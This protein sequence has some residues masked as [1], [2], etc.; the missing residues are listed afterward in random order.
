MARYTA[1]GPGSEN[2]NW[3]ASDK[4]LAVM[5]LN[6][7]GKIDNKDTI[8]LYKYLNNDPAYMDLGLAFYTYDTYK[9]DEDE[10]NVENLLIID[11]HYDKEVNIP[12]LDFV[13]DDWIIHEKFFNY[14]LDM[15]I[16]KYTNSE[17]ITYLQKLLKEAYPEHSYDL[18]FFYP[19]YYNDNMRTIVKDYQKSKIHY[20]YGDLNKD[21]EINNIDLKLLRN[22]LDDDNVI[23]YN[24]ITEYLNNEIELTDDQIKELDTDNNGIIDYIDRDYYLDLV[25]STFSSIFRTR[26][27][28]NQDG[29]ID[30][31]DY[32]LMQACI[33]GE[34]D[35]LKQYDISFILGWCDVQTEALLEEDYNYTGNISE[36]SK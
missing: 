16:Q 29:K 10:E 7:D 22:Y 11:G 35:E 21:G 2:L 1:Q 9:E 12:F 8:V 17:D 13:S 34:S 31:Y 33:N 20:T 19:G 27:D 23:K 28:C 26:A 32:T 24:L 18:N 30:E 15:S 5:D 3:E 4:Q 36:V 25:N 14:L 6:S